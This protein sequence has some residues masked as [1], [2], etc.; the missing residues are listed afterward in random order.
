[1]FGE[2]LAFAFSFVRTKQRQMVSG[3]KLSAGVVEV[4]AAMT[5][6][7]KAAPE[8]RTDQPRPKLWKGARVL[9]HR[10]SETSSDQQGVD[11]PRQHLGHVWG[12]VAGGPGQGDA[13][14]ADRVER[15]GAHRL[16]R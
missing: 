16:V 15:G 4:I 12:G 9:A 14:G 11:E 10:I 5:P 6:S 8:P 1:M 13:H 7:K 2:R 3:K